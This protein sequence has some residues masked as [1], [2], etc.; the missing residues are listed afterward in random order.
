MCY[1]TDGPELDLIRFS[2]IAGAALH[3]ARAPVAEYGCSGEPRTPRLD[4]EFLEKMEKCL[5][6]LGELCPA[7]MPSIVVSGGCYVEKAGMHGSGRA[8]DIDA[9]WWPEEKNYPPLIT[10][11][12]PSDR[13]RYLAAE[14]IIRK[15]CGMVLDYHYNKAHRDHWHI[16]DSQSV[17]FYGTKSRVVFVQS[18]LIDVFSIDVDLNGVWGPVTAEAVKSLTSQLD[19]PDDIKTLDGWLGFLDAVALVGFSHVEGEPD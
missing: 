14:A 5:T 12:Y 8:M 6:E 9:L 10:L 15:H 17:G 13:K 19:T 2:D 3:Y 1:Y 18:A 4:R 7:G 16:D 11:N